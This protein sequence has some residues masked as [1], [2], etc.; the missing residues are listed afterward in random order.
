MRAAMI[1][2]NSLGSSRFGWIQ[3]A[4]LPQNFHTL[5][6]RAQ[7]SDSS[8]MNHVELNRLTETTRAQVFARVVNLF[9]VVVS[10]AGSNRFGGDQAYYII[11]TAPST[12]ETTWTVSSRLHFMEKKTGVQML[13]RATVNLDRRSEGHF[14]PELP[15]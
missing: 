11:A 15:S 8:S 14:V 5:N 13:W 2:I 4:G 10:I 3:L 1:M 7:I 6:V 9:F 12:F